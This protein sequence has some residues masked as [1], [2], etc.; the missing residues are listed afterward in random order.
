M[1][2]LGVLVP[3]MG[4]QLVE[5]LDT[6]TPERVIAV[7]KISQDRIPQRFVDWRRPQR[8][9][10][11]VEVSAVVSFSS[12]QQQSA[13]QIIDIPVPGTR[14]DHGGLQGFHPRQRSLQRTVEQTVDIPADGGLQLFI[15]D[16]GFASSAVS[17]EEL[18]Q[19]I[20][21]TFHREEKVRGSPG[22]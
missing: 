20:F 4:N 8:A 21:R 16:P 10:Q 22:R 3:Q 1:Q 18:G 19:L 15:L 2:I 5:R 11:L 13:E 12:L 6:L 9:E 17:R 7:P 14:G